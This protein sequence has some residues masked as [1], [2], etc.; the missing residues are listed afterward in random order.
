[1]TL[2]R[3]LR[4]TVAIVTRGRPAALIGVVMALW[5]LRSGAHDLE[6][7]FGF[8]SDDETRH[9]ALSI[10]RTD[11]LPIRNLVGSRGITRGHIVNRIVRACR[12]DADVVTPLTDW[13]FPITP[14][15]DDVLAQGAQ[16]FP[17][18]LT[19]WSCPHIPGCVVPA[20]PRAWCEAAGWAISPEIFPFWWDDTWLEEVDAIL[21][22]G[23]CL[24][25]PASF[26]G[27]H[28]KTTRGRDFAFWGRIFA[29]TRHMRIAQA[30]AMAAALGL[31]RPELSDGLLARF[32]ANDR[33]QQDKADEF[34]RI[35]GDGS[36][37]TE[38][39]LAVKSAALRLIEQPAMAGAAA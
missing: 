1:M 8:D 6:F 16:Q 21:S 13:T 4:V 27:T 38:A 7:A 28:G 33:F 29:G 36:Q 9:D 32:E 31:P 10:L 34:E 35:F 15:W 3:R 18:R 5:R 24:K 23:P 12:R 26:A 20:I 25:L 11:N 37:P 17:T 22:G 39:Y 19:W 30:D 2:R 14:G